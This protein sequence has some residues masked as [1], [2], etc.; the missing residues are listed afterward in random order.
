[1]ENTF[2]KF[3]EAYSNADQGLRDIIDSDK[4]GLF[5]DSLISNTQYSNLKMKLIVITSNKLL[6]IFSDKDIPDELTK[7]DVDSDTTQVMSIKILDFIKK[8]TDNVAY[9]AEEGSYPKPYPSNME[10]TETH[11]DPTKT[12]Q[13]NHQSTA[14]TQFVAS[15]SVNNTTPPP[16]PSPPNP[17]IGYANQ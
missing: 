17:P 11:N 8:L 10:K 12:L 9:Q 4:I 6:G 7:L 3:I 14:A 2:E 16:P 1:M 15:G 13:S 5:I